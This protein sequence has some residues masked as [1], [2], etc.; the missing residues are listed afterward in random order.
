MKTSIVILTH[1]QLEYTKLCIESIR[2]Y[3]KKNSYEMIVVDNASI[4]GT[5]EWLRQQEDI[6]SIFNDV[7]LGFPK[8]CNQGI[9]VSSGDNILLLNRAC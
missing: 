9:E 2:K 5:Q 4:D 1:N 8:G 6:L 3:T 7:N